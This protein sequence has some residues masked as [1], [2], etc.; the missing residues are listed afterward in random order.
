MHPSFKDSLARR[1]S[2]S[3]ACAMACSAMATRGAE[4]PGAR[5]AALSKIASAPLYFES[6]AGQ[7]GSNTAF[8]A[9]GAE[10]NVLLAPTEAQILLGNNSAQSVSVPRAVHLQ[11]LGA[12]PA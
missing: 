3:L 2:F 12:N 5:S 1:F 4:N 11:L 10:C 7:F 8:V 9:R 6:N